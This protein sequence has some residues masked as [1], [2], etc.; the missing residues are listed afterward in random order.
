MR[1]TGRCTVQL[2][3]ALV[4]WRSTLSLD[5]QETEGWISE[6]QLMSKRAPALELPRASDRAQL[7][8]GT[9]LTAQ[10]CIEVHDQVV[11]QMQTYDHLYR[12]QLVTAQHGIPDKASGIDGVRFCFFF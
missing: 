9:K 7:R 12:F 11:E 10:Q 2:S 4:M 3:T 6:V 8:K 5:T 1:D